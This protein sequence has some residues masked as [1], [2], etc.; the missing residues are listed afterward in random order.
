MMLEKE[1]RSGVI[2][3]KTILPFLPVKPRAQTTTFTILCVNGF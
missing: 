3:K 1:M 2:G